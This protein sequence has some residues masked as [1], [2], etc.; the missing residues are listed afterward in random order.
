M[1]LKTKSCPRCRG[2]L[3]ID[4]DI[5]GWYE[6]CFQ[7]GYLMFLEQINETG[8]F[9][10]AQVINIESCHDDVMI[11]NEEQREPSGTLL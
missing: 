1:L 8:E 7:C 9:I 2:N 4:K 11:S 6:E 10:P 5:Y 3:Y